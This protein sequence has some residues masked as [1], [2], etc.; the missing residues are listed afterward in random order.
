MATIQQAPNEEAVTA[1]TIDPVEFEI[2]RQRLIAIPDLIEKNIERTAFSLL[3][4]EYKDY[5]VGF[6]DAQ[7]NL[8]TQSRYSLPAFVANALG[9]GVREALKVYGEDNLEV[10]DVV[11]VNGFV[12]GKHLNDV[13]ALTPVRVGRKLIGFFVV[14]VHWIDIGGKVMGS[15][16]ST[17]TTEVW[18]EG[19]QF[20]TMKLISKGERN[21]DLLRL[22]AVNS[23]LPTLLLGDIEAQLGG[24]LTGRDMVLDVV[25][26]YGVERVVA[27]IT[28]MG[29]D[30]AAASMRAIAAVPPGIYTATS[31]LDDDGVDL[32]IPMPVTLKVIV[33]NGTIRIDF[34]EIGDQVKGP[35]NMGRDGGALAFARMAAKILFMPETPVNEGDFAGVSISIPDGKF[36]SAGPNAAIGFGSLSSPTIVDTIFRAL[37][38]ALRE[39]IPAAHHG[40]YGIHVIS[41][42]DPESGEP[43]FSLDAMSGG[44]GAFSSADG[45]SAL[46]SLA[47][48][49]V[50]EVSVEVQEAL[51]PYRIDAKRM[52]IDS[53]G[54]GRRRGGLG[55]EKVYTFTTDTDLTLDV[56]V[57]RTGCPPW[58]LEEGEAGIPASA[59]IV[60]AT[61]ERET[62]RK[63]R[64][65]LHRG[66]QVRVLSG[67]GGGHGRG[68]E[69]DPASVREDVA[70]GYV[71]REAAAKSYGI[72]IADD[73]SIDI[74]ATAGLRGRAAIA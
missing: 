26:E 19:I 48:G 25:D 32:G 8:V 45:P 53:G 29:R 59:E 27:A 2:I 41:G 18:Q 52:R 47:H 64:I 57:E 63:S 7:G 4:Q 46:R 58:G 1:D 5:A 74:D 54:V 37:A 13:A 44:W 17:D 43:F 61:G 65:S 12:L 68:F 16:L 60:R 9:L 39:R 23:R 49:D 33:E 70:E 55:V 56:I 67:G 14:L 51:Y 34:S 15:C 21:R 30:A 3:V 35:C 62:L 40:I 10:G 72:L 42:R 38:P 69:R 36:L 31:F 22:I 11:I 71:S 20:P 24:C 28:A 6:V 73:G 50:R 66:D